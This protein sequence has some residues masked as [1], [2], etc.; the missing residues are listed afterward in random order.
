MESTDLIQFKCHR[1]GKRLRATPRSAGKQF[2]CKGCGATLAV[3]AAAEEP[4]AVTTCPAGT[5]PWAYAG[6]SAAAIVLV[7]GAS[8]VAMLSS[9]GT[10][11][12]RVQTPPVPVV[13]AARESRIAHAPIS[14]AAPPSIDPPKLT[15]QPIVANPRIMLEQAD[16]LVAQG[17]AANSSSAFRLYEQAALAGNAEAMN[18]TGN[19]FFHGTGITVDLGK[20][21]RWYERGA[22]AGNTEALNNLAFCYMRGKGVTK[23][24]RKAFECFEKGANAG[25]ATSMGNLGWCYDDGQGVARDYRKAA[26]WYEK[27]V[28]AGE[29]RFM[30]KLG[31][32]YQYGNGVNQ[33]FHKAAEL[34]EK[35]AAL[36][37]GL[38]MTSLGWLYQ[39]GS[40]VK[41][42]FHEAA[43][44][45]EKAAMLGHAPAMALLGDCYAE[46]GVLPQNG[47]K[48]VEWYGRGAKA[49]DTQTAHKLACLLYRNL[50]T[51]Y[52]LAGHP[53]RG[54]RD[55][56]TL[57][58]LSKT[59]ETDA[60]RLATLRLNLDRQ[61]E[62]FDRNPQEIQKDVVRGLL[63]GEG[64]V[65][66]TQ[67]RITDNAE[68]AVRALEKEKQIRAIL[69]R[70]LAS[71]PATPL[72]EEE[73]LSLG[74]HVRNKQAML[75][76]IAAG[77]ADVTIEIANRTGRTLRDCVVVTEA[78]VD[79]ARINQFELRKNEADKPAYLFMKLLGLDKDGQDAMKLLGV[80]QKSTE[81]LEKARWAYEKCDKG[82]VI[83]VPEWKPGVSLETALSPIRAAMYSESTELAVWTSDG[84]FHAF[85]SHKRIEDAVNRA[86]PRQTQSRRPNRARRSR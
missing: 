24:A 63:R 44:L 58:E 40:G 80:D 26:E 55:L 83:Y 75:S 1:C 53:V 70:F 47:S 38:A 19:C 72:I 3:P 8:L 7:G 82:S 45:Y 18:K 36:G 43:K 31:I 71:R 5:R 77:D 84:H 81:D 6:W 25:I 17:G 50:S 27:A 54:N 73:G 66:Q 42:D 86:F 9:R 51:G 21:F 12:V 28:K 37:D 68:M 60:R 56:T 57:E 39:H 30:T 14:P 64:P 22:S 15:P 65:K 20:A 85:L 16:R 52:I 13:A 23:D 67:G 78:K 41:Q 59:G 61:R 79:V 76:T 4:C 10:K 46:G 32:L 48:A 34:Y 74:Y 11:T 35:A 33:D 29:T 69:N 49:G 2:E 62:E